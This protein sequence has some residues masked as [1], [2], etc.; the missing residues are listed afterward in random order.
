MTYEKC[1]Q[2]IRKAKSKLNH[3]F[4]WSIHNFFQVNFLKKHFFPVIIFVSKKLPQARNQTKNERM[5][6]RTFFLSQKK[7]TQHNFLKNTTNKTVQK[8]GLKKLRNFAEKFGWTDF[9][10]DVFS[11]TIRT[12]MITLI[13]IRA[14]GNLGA[15]S[16]WD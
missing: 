8:I 5:Q 12:R 7:I 4:W 3:F 14:L 2:L 9:S 11:L 15:I 13:N 16:F 6:V 1:R 10:T